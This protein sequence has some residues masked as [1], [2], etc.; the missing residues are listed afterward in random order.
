M[1]NTNVMMSDGC[2]WLSVKE[3]AAYLKLSPSN[4]YKR[5][6]LN[7]IPHYKVEKRVLFSREDLDAWVKR[8][9][10]KSN[11]EAYREYQTKIKN[12]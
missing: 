7:A 4:L 2:K 1:K 5:L 10:V 9:A 12:Q 11:D 3:A 6:M 8:Y